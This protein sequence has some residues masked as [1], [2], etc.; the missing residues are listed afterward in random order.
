MT[1][2][3]TPVLIVGAGPVGLVTALRLASFGISSMLIDCKPHHVRQGSKAC[4]IQGD[5]LEVLDKFGCADTIAHEGVGWRI[6]HTYIRGQ[7]VDQIVYAERPGFTEFVNISQH[8]IEQILLAAV[9]AN[10]L[11]EMHWDH[12]LTRL[13]Q[14][15]SSVAAELEGPQGTL[16]ISASYLVGCDGIHSVVRNLLGV[17]W[18]GYT[19]TD[20]FLITDIYTEL[21]QSRERHFHFDPP[22]NPGRQLVMHPQ[23][24]NMWRIDWQLDPKADIPAEEQ[25]GELDRRIR[26]VIGDRDYTIDWWSTYRFNQRIADKFRIGR[27]MLAG[28]AAHALP[29]YGSRGMNSGIQD[30]DNLAWKLSQMIQHDAPGTLLDSYHDERHAAAREN[31]RV[32]EA[33]IKFM[34]PPSRIARVGRNT[35]LT[36]ARVFPVFKRFLN[37]GRMAAP[38]RYAASD[39]MHGDPGDP[40]LGAFLPDG[41]I[42][43]NERPTRLRELAGQDFLALGICRN[44]AEQDAFLALWTPKPRNLRVCALLKGNHAAA[45]WAE[46]FA[47]DAFERREGYWLLVR[48]DG[49]VVAIQALS[50]DTDPVEILAR[51]TGAPVTCPAE[52][53]AEKE[54]HQHLEA[55]Q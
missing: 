12:K 9:E 52:P 46:G 10:T 49:H 18:Q 38:F 15:T 13:E 34:V 36:L 7:E 32:T 44:Q 35:L 17:E 20:P 4:L 29:P 6:G 14:H 53:S 48:P 40:L 33:T 3:Q 37:S 43:H 41:H 47:P 8:R 42:I 22:F 2:I 5:V 16:N 27:V 1:Q 39:L 26:K 25:S 28:D 54:Q 24:R 55:A 11:C 51:C 19:H 23:P 50:Q 21:E 30:A 45:R 31:L